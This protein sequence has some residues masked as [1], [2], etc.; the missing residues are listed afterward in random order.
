MKLVRSSIEPLAY[1]RLRQCGTAG[2]GSTVINIVIHDEASLA[3]L[4]WIGMVLVGAVG[5]LGPR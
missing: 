5:A 2:F 1:Q 4:Y 3:V